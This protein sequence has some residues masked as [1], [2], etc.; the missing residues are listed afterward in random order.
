VKQAKCH[1]KGYKS[2]KSGQLALEKKQLTQQQKK[3]AELEPVDWF[4]NQ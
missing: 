1:G 2:I 4:I 3:F